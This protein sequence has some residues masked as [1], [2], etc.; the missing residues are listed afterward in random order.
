MHTDKRSGCCVQDSAKKNF[1]FARS[2][3]ATLLGPSSLGHTSFIPMSPKKVCPAA[4]SPRLSIPEAKYGKFSAPHVW[5][6]V[7]HMGRD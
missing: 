7:D 4:D 3:R 6:T 2:R 1:G 5:S